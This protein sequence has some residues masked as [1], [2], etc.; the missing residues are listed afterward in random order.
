MTVSRIRFSAGQQILQLGV[1]ECDVLRIETGVARKMAPDRLDRSEL[2][3]GVLATSSSLSSG[4][5]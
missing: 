3:V 5:K 1:D 2:R 4:G